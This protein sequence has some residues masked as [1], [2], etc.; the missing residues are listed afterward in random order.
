MKLEELCHCS[1]ETGSTTVSSSQQPDWDSSSFHALHQIL[2]SLPPDTICQV[3]LVSRHWRAVFGKAV[4]QLLPGKSTTSQHLLQLPNMFPSLQHLHLGKISNPITRP[5]L[6][7]LSQLSSLS[8]LSLPQQTHLPDWFNQLNRLQCSLDVAL[9]D[10]S[11]AYC[12]IYLGICSQNL[13]HLQLSYLSDLSRTFSSLSTFSRLQTLN[14]QAGILHTSPRQGRY[15][16]DR[17]LLDFPVEP[18]PTGAFATLATLTQLTSLRLIGISNDLDAATAAQLSSLQQLQHLAIYVESSTGISGLSGLTSLTYLC[19]KGQ[20]LHIS[21]DTFNAIGKLQELRSLVLEGSILRGGT[22]AERHKLHDRLDGLA[23]LPHLATLQFWGWLNAEAVSH[24][25]ALTQLTRLTL[26][27]SAGVTPETLRSIAT[28]KHLEYLDLSYNKLAGAEWNPVGALTALTALHL[29]G[30]RRVTDE[31]VQG[32]STL[33]NLQ[34]FDISHGVMKRDFYRDKLTEEG[35]W[36]VG[37]LTSLRD[38]NLTDLTNL[39]DRAVLGLSSLTRLTQI[40]LVGAHAFLHPGQN[41]GLLA[42]KNLLSLD[43]SRSSCIDDM[44]KSE[45]Q[46]IFSTLTNLKQLRYGSDD[47]AYTLASDEPEAVEI[48][49]SDQGKYAK[50][51]MPV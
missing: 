32:L 4:Q 1:H 30:C 35:I 6:S 10:N 40:C 9:T 46:P 23:C 33:T 50:L 18:I 28:L 13:A 14:V 3:R 41:S 25:S 38:L 19:I 49:P 8:L 5:V 51:H 44:K 31:T 15:L 29:H 7:A 20:A 26:W 45:L 47:F 2:A 37:A 17:A 39:T 21:D 22:D 34:W 24:M 27:E 16:L 11:L 43:L 48:Y 12:C 42:M 36:M